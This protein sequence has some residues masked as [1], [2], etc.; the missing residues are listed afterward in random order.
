MGLLFL[1]RSTV[2]A[3]PIVNLDVNP[4][5]TTLGA[6]VNYQVK[7]EFTE[8]VSLSEPNWE[9]LTWAE[10]EN[11]KPP[12]ANQFQ[13]T[14]HISWTLYPLE[15][16][17]HQIPQIELQAKSRSGKSFIVKLRKKQIVVKTLWSQQEPPKLKP[18]KVISVVENSSQKLWII[19]VSIGFVIFLLCCIFCLET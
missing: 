7:M 11:V 15:E 8:E 16:G 9:Q 3:K 5:E 6:A 12:T 2:F 10:V 4:K 14:W 19:G 13:K 17:T 1:A 18:F